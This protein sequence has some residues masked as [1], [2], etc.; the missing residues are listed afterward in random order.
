MPS[1][2]MPSFLTGNPAG[3]LGMA[4]SM[5]GCIVGRVTTSVRTVERLVKAR[6]LVTS[7]EARRIREA[8]GLSLVNVASAVGA[9]PSAIGRWERG[10]RIP[11]GPAALKYAQLLA[12]LKSQQ[13]P[14]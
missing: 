9:D 2:V 10:E 13:D 5:T 12:R 7:G 11:R 8:A 6:A 1:R 14:A 3:F 4:L